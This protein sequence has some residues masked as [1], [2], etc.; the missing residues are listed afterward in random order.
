MLFLSLENTLQQRIM[1]ALHV[2]T[3]LSSDEKNP[4]KSFALLVFQF[5]IK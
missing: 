5:A 1:T 2:K 4:R 3:G